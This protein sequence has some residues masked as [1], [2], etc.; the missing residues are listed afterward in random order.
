MKTIETPR[1][2]L[3]D[4]IEEDIACCRAMFTDP[5]TCANDGGYPP[6]T[7]PK[8]QQELLKIFMEQCQKGERCMIAL[9]DSNEAIGTIHLMPDERR[10]VK[11]TELGYVTSPLH[12]RKGCTFEAVSALCDYL[13]H[14]TDVQLLLA[15]AIE[16]NLP[17]NKLIQKLGFTR[18]GIIRKA[19]KHPDY[20]ICDL[21]SYYKEA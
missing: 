11:A 1:L 21:I 6:V 17:S 15:S 13:L 20:G 18:E 19:A 9:K 4:C 14:E 5:E 12:R 3:R 10:V 2:L 16:Q 7:D 8:E